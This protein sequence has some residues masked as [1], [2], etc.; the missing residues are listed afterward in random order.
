MVGNPDRI[1]CCSFCKLWLQSG[2]TL[3]SCQASAFII[4][5]SPACEGEPSDGREMTFKVTTQAEWWCPKFEET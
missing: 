5:K 4:R 1:Q 3:G 2:P